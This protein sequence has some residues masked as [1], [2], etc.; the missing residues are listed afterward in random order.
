MLSTVI[1]QLLVIRWELLIRQGLKG[2]I[3]FLELSIFFVSC[4]NALVFLRFCVLL[5]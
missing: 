3:L 4:W 5:A 2:W 1:S